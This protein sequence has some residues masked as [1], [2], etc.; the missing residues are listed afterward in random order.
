MSSFRS[1][2]FNRSNQ[3]MKLPKQKKKTVKMITSIYIMD[4]K[5]V[6]INGVKKLQKCFKGKKNLFVDKNPFF[7][8]VAVN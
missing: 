6:L 5:K 1:K 8:S 3:N 4:Y 2:M 7:K